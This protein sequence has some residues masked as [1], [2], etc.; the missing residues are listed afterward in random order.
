MLDEDQMMEMYD[1]DD[2]DNTG[3]INCAFEMSSFMIKTLSSQ[4]RKRS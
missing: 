3:M 2:E 1:E 4:M